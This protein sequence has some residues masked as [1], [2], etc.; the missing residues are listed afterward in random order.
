M[1]IVVL[2][3][4]ATMGAVSAPAAACSLQL[5]QQ[6]LD[7]VATGT[8]TSVEEGLEEGETEIG[9]DDP[10]DVFVSWEKPLPPNCQVG[11]RIKA[12]GF[13]FEYYFLADTISCQ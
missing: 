11:R 5:G 12:V 3:V 8:I 10:C 2:L 1:R 6:G 13:A 4:F 7:S 9:L